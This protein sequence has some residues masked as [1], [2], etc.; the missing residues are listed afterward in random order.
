MNNDSVIV[1]FDRFGK[2]FQTWTSSYNEDGITHGI[3]I[4][5]RISGSYF[6][7]ETNR[8]SLAK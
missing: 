2:Y 6:I 4:A 3:T 8:S 7:I 5:K 1:V